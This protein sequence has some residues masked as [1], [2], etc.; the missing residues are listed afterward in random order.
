MGGAVAHH[1]RT[2]AYLPEREISML[3]ITSSLRTK[4]QTVGWGEIPV[5]CA[6]QTVC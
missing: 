5:T 4:S 1:Q 2:L 6:G 3:P